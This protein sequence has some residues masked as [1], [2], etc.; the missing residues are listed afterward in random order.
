M[1]EGKFLKGGVLTMTKL[2][3]N[4]SYHWKAILNLHKLHVDVDVRATT[5]AETDETTLKK[6]L[7]L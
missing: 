2:P 7:N 1:G 6:N 4:L 3:N 5:V